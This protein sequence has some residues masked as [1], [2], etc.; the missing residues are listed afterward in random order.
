M[1][2]LAI[3]VLVMFAMASAID[4]YVKQ[5]PSMFLTAVILVVA[6]VNMAIPTFG[7]IHMAF[8]VLSFIFAWLIFEAGFIG[9]MADIK[10]ITV[11]GMMVT[12]IYV[13]GLMMGLIMVF[14][15]LYKLVWRVAL[16]KKKVDLIPFLPCLLW[17]YITLLCAGVII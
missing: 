8:G 16:R 5:I 2:T 11:V 7:L 15:F 13:L 12:N 4:F 9:G 3:I 6:T 10:M 1:I 17:V 14:G